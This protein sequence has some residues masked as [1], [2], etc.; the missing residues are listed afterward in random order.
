[1]EKLQ[2]YVMPIMRK[3]YGGTKKANAQ[4]SNK[5]SRRKTV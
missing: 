2:I 3:G 5:T 4:Y 1:M